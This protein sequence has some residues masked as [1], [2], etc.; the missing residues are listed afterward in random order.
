MVTARLLLGHCAGHHV[1][2]MENCKNHG[3]P[4]H[5]SDTTGRCMCR[6]CRCPHSVSHH[7]VGNSSKH[8]AYHYRRHCGCGCCKKNQCC[9]MG[10]NHE[11]GLGLD[12]HYS[13]QC[14]VSDCVL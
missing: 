5:K 10:R 11:P 1:W 13:S 7:H 6:R 12:P 14:F 2:R 8:H 4:N 3:Q 9:K